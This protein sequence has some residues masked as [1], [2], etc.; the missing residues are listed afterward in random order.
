MK[1]ALA[2][3][4]AVI[5]LLGCMSI[6]AFATETNTWSFNS[7]T[8]TFTVNSPV[9]KKQTVGS[10][11]PKGNVIIDGTCDG[12][13][14]LEAI[15]GKVVQ[16]GGYEYGGNH[17]NRADK[18]GAT[19]FEAGVQY[20]Y[21]IALTYDPQTVQK[22]LANAKIVWNGKE[23]SNI[24]VSVPYDAANNLAE[25]FIVVDFGVLDADGSFSGGDFAEEPNNTTTI[26][27]KK[28]VELSYEMV[29]PGTTEL[30]KTNHKDVVLD[31]KA[32]VANV[33]DASYGTRIYYTVDMTNA[34]FTD[35][36]E[37]TMAATYQYAQGGDYVTLN[38]DTTVTVF[39]G[40]K[41]NDSTISVTVSDDEWKKAA[42]ADYTAT[43]V[44]SFGDKE[45]TTVGTLLD[46]VKTP[47]FP[48]EMSMDNMWVANGGDNM[49]AIYTGTFQ[50]MDCVMLYDGRNEE[51][52]A[53]LY[54]EVEKIKDS[55]NYFM[56]AGSLT[57][58]FNMT[59]GHLTSIH[60][61]AG[62]VIDLTFA[63]LETKAIS[64]LLNL[65]ETTFPTTLLDGWF[66]DTGDS[67]CF[68]DN[69]NLAFF[70]YRQGSWEVVDY[71]PLTGTASHLGNTYY[72]RSTTKNYP[73]EFNVQ[74]DKLI[75]I[76]IKTETLKPDNMTIASLLNST[77]SDSYP[78]S[79]SRW[80]NDKVI[81][82]RFNSGSLELGGSSVPNAKLTK[83]GNNYKFKLTDQLTVL[84][85]MKEG[86]IGSVTVSGGTGEIAKYNGTYEKPQLSGNDVI[87][88]YSSSLPKGT[89]NDDVWTNGYGSAI[90]Y[91]TETN[92]ICSH[93]QG[94]SIFDL[95]LTKPAIQTDYGYAIGQSIKVY[96]SDNKITSIELINYI[97]YDN[98]VDDGNGT[99]KEPPLNGNKVL[100]MYAASLPTSWDDGW[101][102]GIGYNKIWYNTQTG[103]LGTKFDGLNENDYDLGAYVA[104]KT[105]YG[106][107]ITYGDGGNG[108]ELH[109]SG[110]AI[111]SIV[112]K[113]LWVDG[114]GNGTYD[115]TKTFGS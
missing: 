43:L 92:K 68:V 80:Y 81:D 64:E 22:D 27:A 74:S 112:V 41:I 66:S 59:S 77:W 110:N 15:W 36:N 7:E 47:G 61:K 48:A 86:K 54:Y 109:I 18:G 14:G 5:M 114:Y 38:K 9:P 51:P 65:S 32:T 93:F 57:I 50:S 94:C 10:E 25:I 67:A 63:P 97:G 104:T 35:G 24:G 73:I 52:I 56:R 102:N 60:A 90:W 111:T 12:I 8:M 37:H 23:Y 45:V 46:T 42:P 99:Y 1:K 11:L 107:L 91:N 44:F 4:L 105:A 26:K 79:D 100:S 13:H 55:E 101:K 70:E 82:L 33:K 16:E 98:S 2:I 83:D 88:M 96:I 19:T 17:W 3:I 113:N 53:P 20:G 31:G 103:K 58:T 108:L 115:A 62:S 6:T 28:V 76:K 106:Y 29:I 95:N 71:I 75:S 87:E 34:N 49:Y 85:T 69:G 89:N 72:A 40:N 39:D 21:I 78:T 30:N 84:F